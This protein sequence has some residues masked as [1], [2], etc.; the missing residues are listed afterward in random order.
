MSRG[1]EYKPCGCIDRGHVDRSV[2]CPEAI[3]LSFKIE[4]AKKVARAKGN[5]GPFRYVAAQLRTHVHH[6]QDLVA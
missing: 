6:P 5:H 1:P 2:M 4:G 3:N